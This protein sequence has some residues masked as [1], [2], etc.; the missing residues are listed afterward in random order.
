MLPVNSYI[1]V[2][3]VQEGKAVS[4]WTGF[5]TTLIDN[6]SL[7]STVGYLPV[8]E[9]SPT[10]MDTVHAILNC[11]KIYA[12]HLNEAAIA[13]VFDQAIYGKAQKI[14]GMTPGKIFLKRLVVCM[15]A[16]HTTM[17]YMACMLVQGC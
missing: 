8:I 16:F 6:V 10:Q 5:N 11:S 1:L 9:L 12:S 15:G 17:T 4:S 3:Q 13:V 14:L 2:H 7:K